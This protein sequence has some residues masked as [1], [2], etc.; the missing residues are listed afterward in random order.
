LR[1]WK[2][3][4]VFVVLLGI[5]W[6]TLPA[7]AQETVIG[8]VTPLSGPLSFGGNE[9]KNGTTL[10]VEK[11]KTLFGK[12][13]KVIVADGPDATACVSEV[14][15]L[16]NQHGIKVI[17]GGYGSALEGATQKAAERLKVLNLGLVNWGDFLTQGGLKYYFRWT[18]PVGKYSA[19]FASQAVWLG[20]EYIKKQPG[21]LRVGI[22]HSDATAFVAD[23][24]VKH[25]ADAGIKIAIK[26]MYPS[27]IKDFTSTIMKLKAAKLDILL[28]AQ[29]TADGLLFRRQMKA[30]KYEPPIMYGAGLIHDQPEFAQLGEAADGVVA[31]SYTNPE[32]NPKVAPG[33]A[34]FRAK[35]IKRFGHPPLTHAL[36]AYAGTLVYL[37]II[38]KVGSFD[39]EKIIAALLK[40][41]LPPGQ[42]AA[43]WGL[44]FDP[45]THQ[46]MRA[47]EPFVMAQWQDGGKFKV[48]W[49]E[50][51]A[52]APLRIPYSK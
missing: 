34:E 45:Q 13:I 38:D 7:L 21:D 37:N 4:L 33:L 31:L 11:K 47:G 50:K 30:M 46:N 22:I 10:A 5:L 27:D 25:L 8:Q 43:Y 40:A 1:N 3:L 2:L 20:K 9:V 6:G 12:P 18:P 29:Y 32:M 19:T 26:E 48:V 44:K 35:Y 52:V 17:L 39:V 24:V 16:V 23:P 14:D 51:F 36:Q 15:R 41:E 28:A 49:P 42:T